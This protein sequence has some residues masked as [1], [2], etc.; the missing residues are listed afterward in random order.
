[1]AE[2]PKTDKVSKMS[3]KSTEQPKP[4]KDELIPALTPGD[5]KVWQYARP[6]KMPNPK[7]DFQISKRYLQKLGINDESVWELLTHALQRVSEYKGEVT[8]DTFQHI[9]RNLLKNVR[10]REPAP[11]R[12]VY[13]EPL[14]RVPSENARG[15]YT[16]LKYKWDNDEREP[17]PNTVPDPQYLE[18]MRL[19]T[20]AGV[21]LTKVEIYDVMIAMKK[22]TE[23][24]NISKARFW[25]KIFGLHKNYY[26]IEADPHPDVITQAKEAEKLMTSMAKAS[27]AAEAAKGHLRKQEADVVEKLR[28]MKEEVVAIKEGIVKALAEVEAQKPPEQ[29]EPPGP[30]FLNLLAKY[31]MPPVPQ[32]PGFK[33]IVVPPEPLGEGLNWKQYYVC[34]NPYDHWVRLPEVTPLQITCARTI[35]RFLTGDLEHEFLSFP[36]FPGKEK[37]LLRAQIA[38]ITASTT[39]CPVGYYITQLGE[40]EIMGDDVIPGGFIENPDY[41]PPPLKCLL[42][43]ERKYWMHCRQY[44]LPQG[45]TKYWKK[46]DDFGEFGEAWADW[47]EDELKGRFGPPPLTLISRDDSPDADKCWSLR[48]AYRSM[49]KNQI[50]MARSNVWPGAF[51]VNRGYTFVNIYV[52]LGTKH[53]ANYFWPSPVP[54]IWWEYEHGPEIM[55]IADPTPEE[56]EAWRLAHMPKV[57]QPP[58]KGVLGEGGE[59]EEEEEL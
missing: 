50:V 1:M 46:P 58:V 25:G 29:P 42:H 34:N 45:R 2:K 11:F 21:G 28:G 32:P 8:V 20:E 26:V 55:E 35:T 18:K 22:V 49:G 10:V 37:H 54:P 5:S 24:N 38:R 39:I 33:E 40:E 6:M 16:G 31:K 43:S 12:E 56:E 7:K 41:H 4:A 36:Q 48:R 51:C 14:A 17:D 3:L 9:I 59:G 30:P 47:D 52:G 44:I 19:L 53:F 15:L 23:Q 57:P 27:A 13:T